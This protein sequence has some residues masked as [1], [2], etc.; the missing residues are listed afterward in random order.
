LIPRRWRGRI[1]DKA[2]SRTQ[3]GGA[4]GHGLLHLL[5]A[6]HLELLHLVWGERHA[7]HP[8]PHVHHVHR[9]V[10]AIHHH[11]LLLLLVMKKG[12]RGTHAHAVHGLLRESIPWVRLVGQ[13]GGKLIVRL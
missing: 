11:R 4:G 13:L 2:H 12:L 1:F 8:E 10:D 6:P 7:F 3:T 9:G 5:R